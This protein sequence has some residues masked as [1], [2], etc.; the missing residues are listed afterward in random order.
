ML[1]LLSVYL[2][3][4]VGGGGDVN[5]MWL[6][7]C[8][9]AVFTLYDCKLCVSSSHCLLSCICHCETHLEMRHP[10]NARYYYYR[11]WVGL[12]HSGAIHGRLGFSILELYMVGWPCPFWNYT[13]WVGLVHSEA[14][15]G[16]LGL[17][18]LKLYMVGWA[19]PLRGCLISADWG[20]KSKRECLL[21]AEQ[22]NE[23]PQTFV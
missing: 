7:T 19:C 12:V 5:Q 4:C 22:Q 2:F 15:H 20:T 11:W 8:Q 23:N 21:S 3:V 13:W 16:E 9:C 6:C 10:R 1:T 18:I 14:I 17:S